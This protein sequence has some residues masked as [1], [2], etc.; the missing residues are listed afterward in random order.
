MISRWRE[1]TNRQSS[2]SEP[3]AWSPTAA[4][5]GCLS[6]VAPIIFGFAT[7]GTLGCSAMKAV[8]TQ[9][10]VEQRGLE[11]RVS[12]IQ[13]AYRTGE[14]ANNSVQTADVL[15]KMNLLKD[16]LKAA[17]LPANNWVCDVIRV[18]DASSVDCGH[19][20]ATYHLKSPKPMPA[21][22]AALQA[23]QCMTFSG[24]VLEEESWT[25]DGA[26]SEPEFNVEMT[27]AAKC[28]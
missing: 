4:L 14:K 5:M 2:A 12:Q 17:P 6:V 19:G 21:V 16:E 8:T 18:R 15:G 25:A 28:G 7:F 13:K 9:V 11:D 24:R 10:P 22:L 23:G 20:P 26:I 1:N 27:G 3:R